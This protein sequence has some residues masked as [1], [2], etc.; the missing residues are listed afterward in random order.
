MKIIVSEK[1]KAFLD[2]QG[3]KNITIFTKTLCGWG[4]GV[5]EPTVLLGKPLTSVQN[6]KKYEVDDKEVYV[7][8]T[9]KT[10]NDELTIDLKSFLW[11]KWLI[12]KGV[13][14]CSEIVC[15]I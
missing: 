9:I 15:D 11:T 14:S 6:F 10:K 13:V 5:P 1:A 2:K 4:G 8:M 7:F 3:S 12:V